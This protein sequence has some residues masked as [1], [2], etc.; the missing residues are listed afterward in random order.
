[1]HDHLTKITIIRQTAS[2]D[3][4]SPC[5]AGSAGQPEGYHIIVTEASRIFCPLP[6]FSLEAPASM[7]DR[8]MMCGVRGRFHASLRL[9]VATGHLIFSAFLSSL[10][11]P[12]SLLDTIKRS[13]HGQH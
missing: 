8:I 6:A 4:Q 10:R 7:E 9:E 3:T 11:V 1:M 12:T 5:R 13:H 2:T